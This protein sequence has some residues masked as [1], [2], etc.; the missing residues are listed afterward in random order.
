MQAAAGQQCGRGS[1]DHVLLAPRAGLEGAGRGRLKVGRE[2][3]GFWE[4]RWTPDRL[5]P[6]SRNDAKAL[7]AGTGG[8]RFHAEPGVA[9]PTKGPAGVRNRVHDI[10]QAQSPSRARH[11][12]RLNPR[13]CGTLSGHPNLSPR[14][15]GQAGMNAVRWRRP[16]RLHGASAG[17]GRRRSLPH[18]STCRLLPAAS[19]FLLTCCR[20][21]RVQP[22]MEPDI[23]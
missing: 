13:A 11:A 21:G 23:L 17:G 10:C 19:C 4:G 7:Q 8:Q 16:T 5:W 9:M 6:M 15:A 14:R 20:H 2:P 12:A 22:T 1:A 18:A 3:G